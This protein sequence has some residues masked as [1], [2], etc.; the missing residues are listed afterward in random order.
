VTADYCDV[1]SSHVYQVVVIR[2][3]EEGTNA[4]QRQP[5]TRA[6]AARWRRAA[7]INTRTHQEMR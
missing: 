3:S 2:M 7:G 4:S 1:T 6:E 5:D